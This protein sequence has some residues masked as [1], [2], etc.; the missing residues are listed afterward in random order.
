[1]KA[2]TFKAIHSLGIGVLAILLFTSCAHDSRGPSST[3]DEKTTKT[4]HEQR[5]ANFKN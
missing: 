4:F 5:S 2:T 3:Q 1:M